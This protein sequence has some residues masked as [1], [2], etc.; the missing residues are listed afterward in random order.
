MQQRGIE[1]DAGARRAAAEKIY[2]AALSHKLDTTL[3]GF[4]FSH[5]LNY[6]IEMN[7]RRFLDLRHEGL[8]IGDINDLRGSESLGRRKPGRMPAGNGDIAAKV[9]C[10]R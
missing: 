3:P 2:R 7:I 6:R 10:K 9:S 5:G 4:R 1:R 8:P